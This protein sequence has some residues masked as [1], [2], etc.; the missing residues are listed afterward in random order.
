MTIY[1]PIAGKSL[2][3]CGWQEAKP[4]RYKPNDRE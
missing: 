4:S 1:Q 2:T 3:R